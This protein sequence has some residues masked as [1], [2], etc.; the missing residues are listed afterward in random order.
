M[1]IKTQKELFLSQIEETVNAT[2]CINQCL[3]KLEKD[4]ESHCALVEVTIRSRGLLIE[5]RINGKKI[6]KFN[7]AFLGL[8]ALKKVVETCAENCELVLVRKQCLEEKV[9]DKTYTYSYM[10]HVF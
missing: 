3:S 7:S 4:Q 10:T 8:A 2:T 6:L 9:G 1:N 5:N